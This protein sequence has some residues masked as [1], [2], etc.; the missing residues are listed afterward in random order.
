MEFERSFGGCFLC[1]IAQSGGPGVLNRT[2]S[3]GKMIDGRW[4]QTAEETGWSWRRWSDEG[5]DREKVPGPVID[6]RAFTLGE[7][8]LLGVWGDTFCCR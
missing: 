6:L 1:Q 2:V 5:N 4:W 8:G 3:V 7:G